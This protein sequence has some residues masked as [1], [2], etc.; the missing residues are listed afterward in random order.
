MP[1]GT[2]K[3]THPK[4]KVFVLQHCRKLLEHSNKWTLRDQEAPLPRKGAPITLDHEEEKDDEPA[5]EVGKNKLR[6][7]RYKEAREERF[8]EEGRCRKVEGGDR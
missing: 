7:I 8:E 6:Y 1:K 4:C 2:S 3:W 5:P